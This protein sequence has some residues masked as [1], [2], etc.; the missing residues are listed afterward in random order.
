MYDLLVIIRCRLIHLQ[1]SQIIISW[2]GQI[3][4]W[5]RNLDIVFTAE[6]YKYILTEKRSDLSAAN[7]PKTELEKYENGLK[8]MRWHIAIF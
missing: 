8:L 6:G 2:L 1:S 7:S 4:D 3:I 5:K